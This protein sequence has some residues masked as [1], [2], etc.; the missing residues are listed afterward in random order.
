MS[1]GQV[2]L[3]LLLL[4]FILLLVLLVLILL[5]LLLGG[6]KGGRGGPMLGPKVPEDEIEPMNRYNSSPYRSG[7]TRLKA[8]ANRSEL[9]SSQ[10]PTPHTSRPSSNDNAAACSIPYHDKVR[11]SQNH[12]FFFL[13]SFVHI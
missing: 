4:L 13:S 1:I 5:L 8:A 2:I 7:K 10:D 3:Q 6:K 11:H 9:W 12:S